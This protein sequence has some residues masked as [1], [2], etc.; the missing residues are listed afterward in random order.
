[1]FCILYAH[2]QFACAT[3]SLPVKT[4]KFT[5]FYAASTSCKIHA[6]ACNK[7]HNSR[8]TSTAGCRLTYLQVVGE[9]TCS[10]IA[11][12]LQ[13]RVLLP[14]IAGI[15]SAIAGLFACVCRYFCLRL[16]VFLPAIT[17]VFAC[18]L[19]V[20]LPAKAG[21]FTCQSWANLHELRM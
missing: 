18:K 21:N 1:M 11:D 10:V 13:L 7:A 6:I 14:V 17:S 8:V 19:Y 12:S 16:R 20:F 9:F 15:L 5:C 4:G 3:C 2:K